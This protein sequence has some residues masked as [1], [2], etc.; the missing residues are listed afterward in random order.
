MERNANYALVG[1]I[2]AII[3]CG[4]AVFV[5]W[6]AGSGFSQSFDTYNILFKGPV[7]GLNQGGEV[8]FNGIKLDPK[9][10]TM[11]VAETRVT[12][13]VPVREDST[14]TLEPQGITGVNYIQITA[15]T[16]NK[17]LLKA[18]TPEGQ[19]PMIHTRPDTFSNLL[20][21]GGDVV[22]RAVET[23]DRV[24]RIL[25]DDNIKTLTATLNNFK[26]VS[27]ELAKRKSIIDDA[28][29]TVQDADVTLAQV[30]EL[31]KSSNGLV[32]GDG[33]RAL[34]K[35]ADA[36]TEIEASA[37]SLKDM[38][39]SLKGPTGDF[40]SNGLPQMTSAL[41]SLQRATEHMDQMITQI[42]NNPRGL[43]SK[44]PA[45]EIEVKP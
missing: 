8:H 20:A 16:P 42:Q 40:A 3:L 43:V 7:R 13:D 5:V 2:S 17:P 25:S 45:K 36:A 32:N 33:K 30:R 31:A 10:A 19:V 23:L 44:A 29:K 15:G 14:A 27:A 24:N 21:G 35:L 1:L 38:T 22:Q 39:D 18:V 4:L 28:Q 6:L 12:S 34:G 26:D 41:I 11:V 9:D 37:K